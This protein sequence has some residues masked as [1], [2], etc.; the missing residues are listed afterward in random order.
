MSAVYY[1]SFMGNGEPPDNLPKRFGITDNREKALGLVLWAKLIDFR[2]V[3]GVESQVKKRKPLS[4][5]SLSKIR[6]SK[7]KR[8]LEEKY[9]LF[10]EEFLERELKA[11]PDF[12]AG[13]RPEL[14][15]TKSE[16]VMPFEEA[17]RFL[18]RRLPFISEH[19][20]KLTAFHLAKNSGQ[21]LSFSKFFGLDVFMPSKGELFYD[22]D[23]R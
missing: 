3:L 14:D 21:Q 11:R 22:K 6:L 17:E 9:G 16:S 2:F 18:L 12:Y 5:E 15:D 7:L 1:V 8:K 13:K 10:Y 19:I 20:N 4:Q 23:E